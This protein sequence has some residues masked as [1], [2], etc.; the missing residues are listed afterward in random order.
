MKN[1]LFLE[2][3]WTGIDSGPF[4]LWVMLY[5]NGNSQPGEGIFRPGLRQHPYN[6]GSRSFFIQR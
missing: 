2:E 5:F 1:D 6:L 4:E 3:E